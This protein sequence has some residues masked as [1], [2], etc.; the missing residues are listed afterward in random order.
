[1]LGVTKKSEPLTVGIGLDAVNL[2]KVNSFKYL[3]SLVDEDE[4]S[5]CDIRARIGIAKATF[6]QL[7][8][9]LVNLSVNRT[10]RVRGLKAHI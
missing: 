10:T 1:M 6:E 7:R 8:E 4:K 3:G 2:R 5:D 9:I